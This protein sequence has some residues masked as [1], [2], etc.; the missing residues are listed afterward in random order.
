MCSR[1]RIAPI[2][3]LGTFFFLFGGCFGPDNLIQGL[4]SPFAWG[5]C[6]IVLIVFDVIALVQIVNSSRSI[7]DK[8][9]WSLIV[10]FFPF[11]GLLLYHFIGKK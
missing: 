2:L 1:I 4:S 9:L 7:G 10:V 11:A 5:P 6:G 8:L 3:L